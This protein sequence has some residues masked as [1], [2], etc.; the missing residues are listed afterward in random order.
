MSKTDK[1]AVGLMLVGVFL[2]YV[3]GGA[4]GW[5]IAVGCLILGLGFIAS[6]RGK[7]LG[8]IENQTDLSLSES[9]VIRKEAKPNLTWHTVSYAGISWNSEENCYRRIP[10]LEMPRWGIF[11]EIV[12][13]VESGKIGVTAGKVKAKITFR[14]SGDRSL[15]A[16][17]AAWIDE[18]FGMVELAPSDTRCL[19]LAV[20]FHYTQD[21]RVP[22]NRRTEPT[23]P[24]SFEHYDIPGLLGNKGTA[25]VELISLETNRVVTVFTADWKW[26]VGHPLRVTNLLQISN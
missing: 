16:T 15:I 10:S 19:L 6:S 18:P 7:D 17:P 4:W 26:E 21:W 14:F 12:N 2:G 22:L 5:V 9:L 13:A 24:P 11:L 1:L 23:K 25:E 8:D 3:I 20:G